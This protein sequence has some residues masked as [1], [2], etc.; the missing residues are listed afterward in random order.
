MKLHGVDDEI[1]HPTVTTGDTGYVYED[2]T[3]TVANG[4][5]ANDGYST[6]PFTGGLAIAADSNFIVIMEIIQEIC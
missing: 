2:F 5:S 4:A 3:L 6:S 1:M